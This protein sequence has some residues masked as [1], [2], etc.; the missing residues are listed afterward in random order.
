MHLTQLYE[1]ML[2]LPLTQILVA[3]NKRMLA[4]ETVK[5]EVAFIS[6]YVAHT[7]TQQFKCFVTAGVY[8]GPQGTDR[9]NEVL[10]VWGMGGNSA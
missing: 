3:F 8:C 10:G 4:A 7:G 6:A 5:W 2:F 1:F 9:V